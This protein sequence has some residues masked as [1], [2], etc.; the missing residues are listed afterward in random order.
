M[1]K[2]GTGRGNQE[3]RFG[4]VKFE[5]DHHLLRN[6]NPG[7]PPA[8]SS[9]SSCGVT[10]APLHDLSITPFFLASALVRPSL[11][12]TQAPAIIPNCL[13]SLPLSTHPPDSCQWSL[14]CKSNGVIPLFNICQCLPIVFWVKSRFL[15]MAYMTHCDQTPPQVCRMV[16]P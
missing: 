10:C 14:T 1:R 7:T 5:W 8:S 13:Y 12:L 9:L 6:Q 16:A 11:C 15:N 2:R 3:L 4:H